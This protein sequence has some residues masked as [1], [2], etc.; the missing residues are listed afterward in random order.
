M[1][2]DDSR[3]PAGRGPR[4]T[5]QADGYSEAFQDGI[6]EASF[7]M[8]QGLYDE[9]VGALE[10][11][12]RIHG[13][14]PRILGRLH[15]A[16]TKLQQ[17]TPSA[18]QP[19]PVQ[20]KLTPPPTGGPPRP[21]TV[22]QAPVIDAADP[23]PSPPIPEF[24]ERTSNMVTNPITIPLDLED[25][26]AA[27]VE[28][29]PVP[30]IPITPLGRR[31][32][33]EVELELKEAEVVS[34]AVEPVPPLPDEPAGETAAAAGTPVPSAPSVSPLRPFERKRAVLSADR[35]TPEP[36]RSK[37]LLL[38][39]G[40]VL[41]ICVVVIILVIALKRNG[42]DNS[43]RSDDT[44]AVSS[45]DDSMR[46]PGPSRRPMARRV[47]TTKPAGSMVAMAQDSA[48]GDDAARRSSD[49]DDPG[50]TVGGD[51]VAKPRVKVRL[52]LTVEPKRANAVVH[53]RGGKYITRRFVSKK[54]K[55]RF[56]EE[57]ITIT[58]RGYVKMELTLTLDQDLERT[59]KLK[60]KPRRMKLFDLGSK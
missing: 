13:A 57:V 40:A 6:A 16:R 18:V 26:S 48:A 15:V 24:E 35:S 51:N 36:G 49:G 23:G 59:V 50:S 11:L 17:A 43:A 34:P 31:P 21:Q 1:S 60:R 19:T 33:I 37:V 53:F 2:A 54:V 42:D 30:M 46:R 47:A 56:T 39:G 22:P 4:R 27:K 5:G 58:A 3:P 45:G 10:E 12:Q 20:P 9:A 25:A 41:L 55:P 7:F 32:N 52:R 28:P 38:L 8:Q 44:Q 29:T 14:D